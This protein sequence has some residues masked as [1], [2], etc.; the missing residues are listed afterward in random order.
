MRTPLSL[1]WWTWTPA[2]VALFVS[3]WAGV[4][5]STYEPAYLIGRLLFGPV[6]VLWFYVLNVVYRK[7]TARGTTN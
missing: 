1:S 6:L 4:T 2:L 3:L 5:A 7:L